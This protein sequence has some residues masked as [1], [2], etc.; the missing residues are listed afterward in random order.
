MV[1]FSKTQ[2]IFNQF[3]SS[4]LV[5]FNLLKTASSRGLIEMKSI[6]NGILLFKKSLSEL[7]EHYYFNN[8]KYSSYLVKFYCITLKMGLKPLSK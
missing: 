1:L 8:K 3:T 7:I 6:F 4:P 2:H 5:F